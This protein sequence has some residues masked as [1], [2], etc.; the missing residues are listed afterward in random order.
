MSLSNSPSSSTSFPPLNSLESLKRGV[1]GGLRNG[2]VSDFV[3]DPLIGRREKIDLE[4]R[5]KL[6]VTTE[7]ADVDPKNVVD[8]R[9]LFTAAADQTLRFFPP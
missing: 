7:S 5:G 6:A 1:N 8:W 9:K 4:Q 2:D 3:K